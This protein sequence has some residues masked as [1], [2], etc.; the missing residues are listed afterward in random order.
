MSLK[1]ESVVHYLKR[2]MNKMA[3]IQVKCSNCREANISSGKLG[4][5]GNPKNIC[6]YP[7]TTHLKSSRI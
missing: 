5:P 6:M 7:T 2:Q 4:N 1:R 3:M